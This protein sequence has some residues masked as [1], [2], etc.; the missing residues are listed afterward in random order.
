ME[1]EK[2][3]GQLIH[4]IQFLPTVLTL[5]NIVCGMTAVMQA[6]Q[7]LPG[8]LELGEGAE[9]YLSQGCWLIFAAMLFD[10][11]DGKAARAMD[12][13]SA[14]GKE[15]DSLADVIS[16]GAAP[17]FVANR[18][19][20]I[21]LY[22]S[23]G[24]AVKS[25]G[26]LLTGISLVFVLCAAMR[27][28]RYNAE[29]KKGPPEYLTGLPS[30]AAGGFVVGNILFFIKNHDP[31]WNTIVP[32]VYFFQ[33]I[34]P[35]AIL[36]AAF[37]MVSRIRFLH[38]GNMLTSRMKSFRFLVLSVFFVLVVIWKPV[39]VFF[40]GIWVYFLSGVIPGCREY[41]RKWAASRRKRTDSA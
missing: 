40:V 32:C 31:S 41:Y 4:K 28:A 11:M 38:V 20:I 34:F 19:L 37:L 24:E 2:E 7:I 33:S 12:A 35:V 14:F 29:T 21:L 9:I 30:P 23:E 5:G 22:S 6:A 10:V 15:L 17:A 8:S 26:L 25:K 39:E 27:L 16:F 3:T 36:A 13:V 1:S 18:F